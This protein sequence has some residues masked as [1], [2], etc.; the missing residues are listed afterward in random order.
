MKPLKERIRELLEKAKYDTAKVKKAIL[1]CNEQYAG[2]KVDWT[3]ETVVKKFAEAVRNVAP[4]EKFV[5]KKK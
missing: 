5:E 3:L 1:W 4:W 2:S